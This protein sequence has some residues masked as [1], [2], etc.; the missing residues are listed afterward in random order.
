[1]THAIT[2]HQGLDESLTISTGDED[3]DRSFGIDPPGSPVLK[4]YRHKEF[5]RKSRFH[6][7]RRR[8]CTRKVIGALLDFF[9]R[10]HAFEHLHKVSSH[11]LY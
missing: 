7:G 3:I 4:S 10:P 8:W 11:Y 6:H 1:M 9:Q 5:G 2:R